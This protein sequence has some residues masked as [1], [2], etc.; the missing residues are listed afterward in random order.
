MEFKLMRRAFRALVVM[1]SAGSLA[2]SGCAEAPHNYTTAAGDVCVAERQQL[3]SFQDYFFQSMV[4]GAAIGAVGGAMAGLLLGGDAKGALIGAGTGA[5]IGGVGGYYSAKAKATSNPVQLTQSVYTDVNNENTQIDSLTASFQRLSECRLRSAQAVKADY[6]AGKINQ[7]DAQA[8]LNQIKSWYLEDIS[9]AESL[10]AKMNERGAEY[11]NASGELMKVD[12]TAQQTLAQRQAA[13]QA[14]VPQAPPPPNQPAPSQPAQTQPAQTQP[15]QG[16]P[17]QGP[18]TQ[19]QYVANEA[20]R[21]RA[22]PSTSG[23]EIEAVTPGETVT[24][25]DSTRSTGDWM[26][27]QLPDGQAGYVASRLLRPAGAPASATPPAAP[28]PQDAAGVAQLT[29]TNQ[30]KRKA[31]NDDVAQAKVT[32]NTAFDLEGKISRLPQATSRNA[33]PS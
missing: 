5:I 14:T 8:K 9:F 32:A 24:V 30:L 2:L 1:V 18:P 17:T 33:S 13:A 21:L 4:Q 31:L 10:G 20:A 6:A 22:E 3:K 15:A 19:G 12:P 27:V 28:P 29:E 11:D 7:A 26:H 25:M 23:A 16:Q